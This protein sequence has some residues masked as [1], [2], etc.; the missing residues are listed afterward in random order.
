MHT[1]LTCIINNRSIFG[2]QQALVPCQ[3]PNMFHCT[4]ISQ[5]PFLLTKGK[6]Q[7]LPV[8]VNTLACS[9]S[10]CVLNLLR[11]S[12]LQL[13]KLWDCERSLRYGLYICLPHHVGHYMQ[14]HIQWVHF[15]NV[16]LSCDQQY[17]HWPCAAPQMDPRY[18]VDS[19]HLL[20]SV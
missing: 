13:S 11:S 15:K 3:L 17:T 6:E 9:A 14:K 7:A 8:Q 19:K 4:F 1:S 2:T 12:D 18:Q 16:L 10:M 20:I 5:L